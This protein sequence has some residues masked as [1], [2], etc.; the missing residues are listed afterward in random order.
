MVTEISNAQEIKSNELQIANQI[1]CGNWFYSIK[2][3]PSLKNKSSGDI[4]LVSLA[5]IGDIFASWA[6]FTNID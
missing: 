2:Y 1:I 4:T 5:T 3:L 6:P